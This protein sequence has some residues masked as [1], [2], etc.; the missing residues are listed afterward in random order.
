VSLSRCPIDFHRAA[1][2]RKLGLLGLKPKVGA[3][4]GIGSTAVRLRLNDETKKIKG[5]VQ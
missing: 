3:G 2:A 1:G 4:R 5:V